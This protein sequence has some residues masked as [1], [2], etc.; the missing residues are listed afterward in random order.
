[1]TSSKKK[2]KR[3]IMTYKGYVYKFVIKFIRDKYSQYI[4]DVTW[5]SWECYQRN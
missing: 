1:M 3:R 5:T 4:I 2:K